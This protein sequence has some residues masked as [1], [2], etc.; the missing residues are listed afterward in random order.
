MMENE[1]IN[2]II[3]SKSQQSRPAEMRKGALLIL[4]L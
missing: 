1:R 4:N 2:D 3:S